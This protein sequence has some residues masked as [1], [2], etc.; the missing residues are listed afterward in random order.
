MVEESDR[1]MKESKRKNTQLSNL[2][3]ETKKNTKELQKVRQMENDL[4]EE[5]E[6]LR[7]EQVLLSQHIKILEK[8]TMEHIELMEIEGQSNNSEYD[9]KKSLVSHFMTDNNLIR[10]DISSLLEKES[11]ITKEIRKKMHMSN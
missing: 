1:I 8:K 4:L 10:K 9:Q 6:K 7:I 5:N 11:E 2:L 3:Q